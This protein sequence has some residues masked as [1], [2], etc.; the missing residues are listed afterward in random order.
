MTTQLTTAA[1]P[2]FAQACEIRRDP[3][4]VDIFPTTYQSRRSTRR[5]KLDG[6]DVYRINIASKTTVQSYL[7]ESFEVKRLEKN[8]TWLWVAG[9][10]KIARPLHKQINKGRSIVKCEQADC[11][12]VWQDDKILIKPMPEYLLAH[13][14]WTQYLDED[15]DDRDE[16]LGFMLSY[17]WLICENS[18]F[19]I[20]KDNHLLPQFVEWPQ[21]TKFA[22]SLHDHFYAGRGLEV[23]ILLRYE[24]GELR[25]RRLNMICRMQ[26]LLHL[27]PTDLLH[28][29]RDTYTTYKSFFES[30]TSWL[31]TAVVYIGVVLTA[32]QVGLATDRFEES[33][34]FSRIC[35][36][37][38]IFSILAPLCLLGIAVVFLLF[39]VA[40]NALHAWRANN[41]LQK[42]VDEKG[43]PTA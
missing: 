20:A 23:S 42:R 11:H 43:R 34:S 30:H 22:A 38:T 10:P 35:S 17:L 7:K 21:W 15:G 39:G 5:P 19:C 9:L 36:G 41:E 13:N 33:A 3:N 37:F 14:T 18:D 27:N 8:K 1:A 12:L 31:V 6:Y 16:V 26:G 25:L 28:G 29:Y 2:P 32:M 24:Y 40:W 4:T